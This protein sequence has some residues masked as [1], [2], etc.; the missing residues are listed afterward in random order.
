[1]KMEDLDARI[2]RANDKYVGDVVEEEETPSPRDLYEDTRVKIKD[3]MS[4]PATNGARAKLSVE[5]SFVLKKLKARHHMAKNRY[6][7][8]VS[9]GDREAAD[10]FLAQYMQEEFLPA[11]EALVRLNSVDEIL[12]SKELLDEMDSYA[13]VRGGENANGYT[14]A[15]LRSIYEDELGKGPSMSDCAVRCC[16]RDISA[17]MARGQVR[18]AVGKAEKMLKK[19]DAGQQIAIDDDYF[20]LQKIASRG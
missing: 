16:M 12:N 1:M 5:T 4:T 8:A 14:R 6:N 17:L 3:V 20:V 15:F 13:L 10:L 19:I 9:R 7:N 2:D 11:V 18:T